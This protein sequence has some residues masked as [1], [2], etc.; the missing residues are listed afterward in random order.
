MG[1]RWLIDGIH[2]WG[3]FYVGVCIDAIP[4]YIPYTYVYSPIVEGKVRER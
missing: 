2:V 1:V 3:D 4:M